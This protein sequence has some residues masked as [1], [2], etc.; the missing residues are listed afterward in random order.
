[1]QS[2]LS[3]ILSPLLSVF[4]TPRP[5]FIGDGKTAVTSRL[6][7]PPE[8]IRLHYVRRPPSDK[9]SSA[10]SNTFSSNT[11]TQSTYSNPISG[12]EGRRSPS[13]SGTRFRD[14]SY[15]SPESP[16][17]SR[18][19]TPGPI[20]TPSSP[21][22]PPKNGLRT[23]LGMRKRST[24]LDEPI[25][26][27]PSPLTGNSEVDLGGSSPEQKLDQAEIIVFPPTPSSS[28]FLHS[29]PGPSETRFEGVSTASKPAARFVKSHSKRHSLTAA[30]PR[31]SL[32]ISYS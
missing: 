31:K 13:P 4:L 18:P 19:S 22:K 27:A 1:M 24:I 20:S 21:P 25:P 23:Y 5:I 26:E 16:A 32:V 3:V 8:K 6:Q 15:I 28:V 9:S 17:P 7:L 2:V 30:C 10:S 12:N 29:A 14:D 11:T